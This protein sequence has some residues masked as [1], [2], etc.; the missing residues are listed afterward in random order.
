MNTPTIIY[1][2][3][4]SLFI[5]VV[6]YSRIAFLLKI[7]IVVSLVVAMRSVVLG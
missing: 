2:F 5:Y 6:M 1:L 4:S 3:F 7:F